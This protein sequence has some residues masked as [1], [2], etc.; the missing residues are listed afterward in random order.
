MQNNNFRVFGTKFSPV[1]FSA[2]SLIIEKWVVTHSLKDGYLWA[3]LLPVIEKSLPLPLNLDLGT[4]DYDLGCSP[5]E[6]RS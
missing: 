1:I 6:L 3:N 2:Q 4:L 5:F